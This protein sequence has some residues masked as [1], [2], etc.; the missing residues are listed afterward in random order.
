MRCYLA[1]W[2]WSG[3]GGE[4][5]NISHASFVLLTLVPHCVVIERV[6]IKENHEAIDGK[7]LVEEEALGYGVLQ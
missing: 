5:K 7:E 6:A 4:R 2:A 1:S 3:G